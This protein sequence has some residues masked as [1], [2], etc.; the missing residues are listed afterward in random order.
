MGEELINPEEEFMASDEEQIDNSWK[1]RTLVIGGLIGM[2]T[3]VS[4]AYLLS[5]RAEQRGT[6]LS[7]SPGKGL[8]L[9]MLVTG[10]LRSILS[11]GED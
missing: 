9:G 2:L 10:L 6:A 8:Q 3:G 5:K 4:A 7:I 1:M 11:M